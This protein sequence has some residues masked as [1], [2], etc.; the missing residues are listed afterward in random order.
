MISWECW[1]LFLARRVVSR[2][3]FVEHWCAYPDG[4]PALVENHRGRGGKWR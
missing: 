2:G 3:E 1:I 4:A